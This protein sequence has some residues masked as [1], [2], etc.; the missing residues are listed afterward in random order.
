MQPARPRPSSYCR[1]RPATP[2][3]RRRQLL[4]PKPPPRF[5]PIA[6]RLPAL[7][8]NGRNRS[9]ARVT[10]PSRPHSRRSY[11]QEDHRRGILVQN[12]AKNRLCCRALFR[13]TQRLY[14][15]WALLSRRPRR[16]SFNNP[17]RF[18]TDRN[19]DAGA[20]RRRKDAVA[21]IH[22]AARSATSHGSHDQTPPRLRDPGQ[23]SL[24]TADVLASSRAR[25]DEQAKNLVRRVGTRGPAGRHALRS[26]RPKIGVIAS[27]RGSCLRHVEDLKIRA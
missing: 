15:S 8:V 18:L 26:S 23:Q 1:A 14:G 6:R 19:R 7:G 11:S 17:S 21:D 5:E 24:A 3:P 9:S 16:R 25:R 4:A 22:R 27:C 20:F 2:P 13:I 12:H 10:R